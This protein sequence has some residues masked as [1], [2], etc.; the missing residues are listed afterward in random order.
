[1]EIRGLPAG[2]QAELIPTSQ[3][4]ANEATIPTNKNERIYAID[5]KRNGA[6]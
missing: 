1:M 3:W 2:K 5:Y 4:K 6:S